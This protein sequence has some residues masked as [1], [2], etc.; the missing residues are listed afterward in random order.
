MMIPPRDGFQIKPDR[1]G[2]FAEPGFWETWRA[3][4]VSIA[5]A[6]PTSYPIPY[7]PP[8]GRIPVRFDIKHGGRSA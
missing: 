4:C 1:R 7:K 3:E 5:G 8:L 6:H 2:P